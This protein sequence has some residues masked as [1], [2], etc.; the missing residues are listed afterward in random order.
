MGDCYV[1]LMRL[2]AGED[3]LQNEWKQPRP[4][5]EPEGGATAVAL[6]CP[7]QRAVPRPAQPQRSRPPRWLFTGKSEEKEIEC[8]CNTHGTSAAATL[9]S[10]HSR[11]PFLLTAYVATAGKTLHHG[12]CEQVNSE[13]GVVDGC[14]VR[15]SLDTKWTD[16][17]AAGVPCASLVCHVIVVRN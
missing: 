3:G 1:F 2:R 5:R 16:T 17:V 11:S 15:I 9:P 14:A 10:L 6:F 12:P 8:V 13:G 4:R 7:W